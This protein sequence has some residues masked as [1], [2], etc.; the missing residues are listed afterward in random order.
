MLDIISVK[1]KFTE[2]KQQLQPI[3]QITGGI[4]QHSTVLNLRE[5]IKELKSNL[6]TKYE[7]I[8]NLNGNWKNQRTTRQ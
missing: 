3:A 5:S 2:K 1:I 8:M 4:R 6:S 7:G